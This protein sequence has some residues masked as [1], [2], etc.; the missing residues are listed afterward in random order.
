MAKHETDSVLTPSTN[1]GDLTS[2]PRTTILLNQNATTIEDGL[3]KALPR[4]QELLLPQSLWS[5]GHLSAEKERE[6]KKKNN[7]SSCPHEES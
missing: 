5:C 7:E 2:K 4:A 6:K 3:C 1:F